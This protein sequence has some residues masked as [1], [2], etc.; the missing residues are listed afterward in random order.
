MKKNF[1]LT[2]V[3]MISGLFINLAETK[4]VEVTL[5]VDESAERPAA[6]D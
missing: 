6:L 2:L 3:M 1:L 4:A 5:T